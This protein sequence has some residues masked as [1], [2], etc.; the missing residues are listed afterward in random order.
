MNDLV[1]W[2]VDLPKMFA[3]FGEWLVTPLDNIGFS[4][5]ALFGVTGITAIIALKAF[6]LAV[7]G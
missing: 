3:Q 7:G 2:L 1:R 6:R 4:P 5:L